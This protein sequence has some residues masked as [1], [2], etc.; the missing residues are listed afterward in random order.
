M[1]CDT[2]IA[3]HGF[4]ACGGNGDEFAVAA[5]DRI[6]EMPVMAFDLFLHNFKIRNRSQ[7]FRV[8]VDQTFVTVNQTLLVQ[9]NEHLAD[10]RR[11]S[12]VHGEPF[13]VPIR[14]CAETTQLI[15]N[16]PA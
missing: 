4:R 11:K 13:A 2:G 5:F 14:G 16:C 1:N 12:F 7:Q 8:P 10:R 9:G 6:F 3:K 15:G